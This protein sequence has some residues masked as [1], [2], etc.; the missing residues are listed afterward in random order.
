MQSEVTKVRIPDVF[1]VAKSKMQREKV[2][3]SGT[4]DPYEWIPRKISNV[5]EIKR[6]SENVQ[7]ELRTQIKPGVSAL[8]VTLLLKNEI[9]NNI[10]GEE[11][12][13]IANVL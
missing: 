10:L 5:F 13:L 8:L 6:Q 7:F 2:T 12:Y 4:T 3:V 9:Q 1:N 11:P